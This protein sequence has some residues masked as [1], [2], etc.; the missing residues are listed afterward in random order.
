MLL[1]CFIKVI[2]HRVSL[3]PVEVVQI[4]GLDH[5]EFVNVEATEEVEDLFDGD[6]SPFALIGDEPAPPMIDGEC[7]GLA[8]GIDLNAAI[9]DR[10][11]L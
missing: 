11:K 9:C 2:S 6:G 4:L 5:V 10:L 3:L 8:A 7:V 1:G